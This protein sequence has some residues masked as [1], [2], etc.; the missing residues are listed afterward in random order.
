MCVDLQCWLCLDH[1][2]KLRF[3]HG[4]QVPAHAVVVEISEMTPVTVLGL[5]VMRL[6][7]WTQMKLFG[8]C[9]KP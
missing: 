1:R 8:L 2:Q 7:E 6:E 5:D 3:D 4:R 9:H